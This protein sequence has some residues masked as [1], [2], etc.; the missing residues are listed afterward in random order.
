M[1]RLNLFALIFTGSFSSLALAEGSQQAGFA[2]FIPLIALVVI[3]YFLLIRPQQK[4]AKDHKTLLKDISKGDEVLTN[5]GVLAKVTQV[6][7]DDTFVTLE[8]ASGVE[9]KV[10]KQAI[11]QRMPKGTL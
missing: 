3:F 8:I 11:N 7:E 2:S 5:G 1:T 10:Q 6:N 4:R 9:V